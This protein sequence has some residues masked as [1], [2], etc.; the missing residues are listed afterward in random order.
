MRPIFSSLSRVAQETGAAIVLIGHRNKSE[1]AKDIHR[2]LGS[3]D[4]A[5]AVRSILLVEID[6]DDRKLRTVKSIS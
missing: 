1:G 4:I 2:G 5:A 6:K 3:A